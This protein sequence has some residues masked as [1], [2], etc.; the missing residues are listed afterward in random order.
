VERALEQ[1]SNKV[2]RHCEERLRDEAIATD[3]ICSVF[4]G[5]GLLGGAVAGILIGT[6]FFSVY[7]NLRGLPPLTKLASYPLT[8]RPSGGAIPP[9]S[10]ANH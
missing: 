10:K 9:A 2:V 4:L 1:I 8:S 3:R 5:A 6:V 7:R